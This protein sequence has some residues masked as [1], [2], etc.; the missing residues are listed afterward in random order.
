MFNIATKAIIAETSI[1]ASTT[2]DR[3]KATKAVTK[4][5]SGFLNPNAAPRAKIIR[6][7]VSSILPPRHGNHYQQQH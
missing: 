1:A 4:L 7:I 3:A 6:G 2:I 5:I